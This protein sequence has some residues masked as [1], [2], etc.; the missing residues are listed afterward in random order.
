MS[1]T[2]TLDALPTGIVKSV[3]RTESYDSVTIRQRTDDPDYSPASVLLLPPR[4]C[5][6]EPGEQVAIHVTPLRPTPDLEEVVAL[7]GSRTVTVGLEL[8]D[9]HGNLLREVAGPVRET[10]LAERIERLR[11][12]LAAAVE[13]Y[14][15]AGE[16][17]AE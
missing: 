14:G 15:G 17:G 9:H 5:K 6:L 11:A 4:C 1:G 16:R 7:D 8:R 12:G 13:A 10:E 3:T 2:R